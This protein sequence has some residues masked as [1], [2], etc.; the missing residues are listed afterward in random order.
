M[1]ATAVLMSACNGSAHDE[2]AQPWLGDPFSDRV[3]NAISEALESGAG[4]V[5][6][7][8]LEE[9]QRD[10]E[11]SFELARRAAFATV[12]CFEEHGLRA[13]YMEITRENGLTIPNYR[14]ETPA[15]ATGEV[16]VI[17]DSCATRESHWINLL[18][19]SQPMARQMTGE[20]VLGKE[21]ELRA[22]LEAQGASP[23]ADADG[24]ELA[25]TA[26]ED[27]DAYSRGTDCL[28]E[29]GIDGL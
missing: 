29:V 20:Y 6:L 15:D 22:C 5:Q 26:L 27:L 21:D 13:S 23:D 25:M 1:T 3:G 28:T 8:A 2:G 7:D 24:W 11:V 4:T 16:Q 18:Y 12:E 10:G 14:I 17:I 19:Q 9:I